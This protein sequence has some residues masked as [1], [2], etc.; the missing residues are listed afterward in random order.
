[1][2]IGLLV[3]EIQ[4]EWS[5]WQLELLRITEEDALEKTR[6]TDI[7]SRNMLRVQIL[8]ALVIVTS[9][10]MVSDLGY[11]DEDWTKFEDW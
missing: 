11:F 5:L 6:T 4:A 2:K 9:K 1:M 3:V 7:V 8:A 10:S